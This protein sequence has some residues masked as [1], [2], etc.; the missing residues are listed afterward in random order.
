MLGHDVERRLHRACR[1]VEQSRNALALGR[2]IGR[3]NGSLLQ[4]VVLGL[5][6]CPLGRQCR[7]HVTAIEPHLAF[8]EAGQEAPGTRTLEQQMK[9]LGRAA[10]VEQPVDVVAVH[11]CIAAGIPPWPDRSIPHVAPAV[12]APRWPG[13]SPTRLAG[14]ACRGARVPMRVVSPP[15]GSS[16]GPVQADVQRT[17]KRGR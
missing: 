15:R 14:R 11:G 10:V 8:G 1:A 2:R 7:R 5:S 16:L 4:L 9:R 13:G 12:R 3:G 17:A 6:P